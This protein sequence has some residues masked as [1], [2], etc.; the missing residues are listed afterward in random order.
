MCIFNFELKTLLINKYLA[1]SFNRW[2]GQGPPWPPY[3][4]RL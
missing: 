1:K 2:G 4:L 3:N